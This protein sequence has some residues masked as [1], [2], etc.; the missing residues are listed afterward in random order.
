MRI[1]IVP[2]LALML[3]GCLARTAIDV[4][5]LPVHAVGKGVDWATT[6]QAESDRN[7][8][9]MM[10]KEEARIRE[11]ERKEARKQRKFER[12]RARDD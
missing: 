6:S 3:S 2:L 4:V 8:G 9:R 7:R 1:L 10:R 5:S 11:E 12:E